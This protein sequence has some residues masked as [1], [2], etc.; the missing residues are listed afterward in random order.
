MKPVFARRR[1]DQTTADIQPQESGKN[2]GHGRQPL[3]VSR[4]IGQVRLY[5]RLKVKLLPLCRDPGDF[6]GLHGQA[7]QLVGKTL[8]QRQRVERSDFGTS[9]VPGPVTCVRAWSIWSCSTLARRCSSR[10]SGFFGVFIANWATWMFVRTSAICKSLMPDSSGTG[11][12]VG[13]RIESRLQN[14]AISRPTLVTR[15]SR[16]AN[17]IAGLS[18]G[19]GDRLS[20]DVRIEPRVE[21]VRTPRQICD[22]VNRVIGMCSSTWRR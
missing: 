11:C 1:E 16:I 2:Y 7:E 10:I 8:L 5:Y 13:V 18:Q 6:I 3:R 17:V 9:D 12:F 22:T 21:T 15:F 14:S 19:H 4:V 20:G